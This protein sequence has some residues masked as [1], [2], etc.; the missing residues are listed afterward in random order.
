[1]SIFHYFVLLFFIEKC[2]IQKQNKKYISEIPYYMQG[3]N[4]DTNLEATTFDTWLPLDPLN[5]LKVATEIT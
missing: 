1:M 5:I 2:K 3:I 4:C